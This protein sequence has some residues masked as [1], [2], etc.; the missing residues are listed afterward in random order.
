MFSDQPVPL[1]SPSVFARRVR[2]A[3]G[4]WITVVAIGLA[5][6]MSGYHWIAGEPW[7]DAF[8]DAAMILG[9]MGQVN[10]LHDGPSKTFAGFY[11]LFAGLAVIAVTA[12]VIGPILHRM[13]HRFHL[14]DADLAKATAEGE[15]R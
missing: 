12:V 3:L 2:H 7:V 15:T 1:A 6:G 10:P 11:A 9:G 13:L 4:L 14:D 8:L 5:I